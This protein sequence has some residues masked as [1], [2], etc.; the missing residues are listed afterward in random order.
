MLIDAL[1]QH[2]DLDQQPE[3]QL[4]RRLSTRHRNRCCLLDAHK[5]KIPCAKKESSR[6]H[7][8][9]LNAYP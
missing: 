7:R 2:R 8:P 1:A 9:H 5:R 4:T 3:H 6:S